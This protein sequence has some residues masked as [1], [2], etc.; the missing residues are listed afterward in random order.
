MRE[1]I[2][3][4]SGGGHT[5]Y[6]VALAQ[7][8][9][10]R[11]RMRFVI[12][13]GDSWSASKVSSYG[14]VTEVVKL[15]GPRDSWVKMLVKAPKAFIQSLKVLPKGSHVFVS[16]GSNHS[17]PPALVSKLVRGS[18]LISIESSVRFTR[19]SSSVK[20][21]RRFAD[22]TVL[23]WEEQLKLIPEGTVVGPLYEKPEYEIGNEGYV[24]VT[25]GTY[26]HKAL[27]DAVLKAGIEKVVLQTGRVDPRPYK[28]ARP[29]WVIFR[30]DPNFGRW[31]A[32]A[33][34][35]VTHLGKTVIDA[36]LTYRKPVVIVPNPEW[37]LTAGIEDAEILARKLNAEVVKEIT[38]RSIKEAIE[39]VRGREPPKYRDGAEELAK[40]ITEYLEETS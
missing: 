30:F 21:L 1:V 26:G 14:E 17:V 9:A 32:K 5:G 36:A 40:I 4:A 3:T 29:G 37:R 23:Q 39:A 20:F 12:P 25:G 8:L 6:A 38:P 24:L 33:D 2:I 19:A 10:G 27:F 35:V 28:R 22:L 31:L 11:V 34:V 18:Y 13:E 16:T 7:R 15:R